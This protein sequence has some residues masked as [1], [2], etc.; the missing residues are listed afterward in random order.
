MSF[1]K[2]LADAEKDDPL[3]RVLSDE[4]IVIQAGTFIFAGT[5]TTAT[6]LTHLIWSVLRDPVIQKAMEEELAALDEPYSDEKLEA[7]PVL[8]AII[9]ETLRLYG[10][11]PA[12]LPRVTPPEGA[13]LGGYTVPT[14]TIVATQ[15]WSLHRD[16]SVFTNPDEFDHTR[17][18]DP[19]FAASE[20]SQSRLGSI[21]SRK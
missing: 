17:W 18:L 11:A 8:N 20:R 6:T 1:Q 3:A 19:D 16:P 14:G 15:A 10:A 7:L 9:K 5:D 12:A 13:V 2:V 4:E 21:R